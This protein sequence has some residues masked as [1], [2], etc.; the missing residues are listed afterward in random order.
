MVTVPTLFHGGATATSD[1]PFKL[2]IND[3]WVEWV[4]I[5]V[6]TNPALFGD[7]GTQDLP[8]L[9][10]DIYYTELPINLA[11]IYIKNYTAGSNVVLGFYAMLMTDARKKALGLM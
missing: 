3:C 10:N 8:V 2:S 7:I 4:D 11:D 1:L 6:I 9:A 5:F